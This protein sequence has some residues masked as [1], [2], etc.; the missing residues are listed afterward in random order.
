MSSEELHQ[1]VYASSARFTSD[2]ETE[3]K[4]ILESANRFNS[5]KNI[6]GILLYRGGI[7]LQLLEG[8]QADIEDLFYN[9]IKKDTRHNNVIELVK[10][11]AKARLFP[12]W[13]MAYRSVS[14][15]DVKM[16]NQVLSW[17]RMIKDPRAVAPDSIMEMLN[18]VRSAIA[19][20]EKR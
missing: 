14:D 4:A 8:R 5:T 9:R 19:A 17:S 7:F 3:N 10:Q 2:A 15:L 1:I 12:D 11:P 13:S 16:I 6:T 20:D 18:K